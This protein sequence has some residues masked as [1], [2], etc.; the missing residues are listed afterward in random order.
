M[1]IAACS[2]TA[3]LMGEQLGGPDAGIAFACL[4]VVQQEC[5]RNAQKRY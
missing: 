1:N 2:Q 4:H 5:V 3:G